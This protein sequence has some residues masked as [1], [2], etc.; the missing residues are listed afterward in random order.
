MREPLD[1]AA[2]AGANP[3]W[4][5]RP[6]SA[7]D[8]PA[9][10]DLW[11]ATAG[12]GLSSSDSPESLTRHLARNPEMSQVAVLPDARLVGAVLCGHDGVRG[13]IRHLAV[14]ADLRGLGI[15][16]RLVDRCLESLRSVGLHK[17][18]IFVFADN[19][20]G[21]EFWEHGGWFGRPDL[22]VMQIGLRDGEQG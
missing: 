1:P 12:V 6:M 10:R 21:R 13:Y 14:A 7:A 17:C 8:L 5:V 19:A 9:V 4:I 2:G 20:R 3:A 11:Q 22:Q 15:G 18:T 16:R